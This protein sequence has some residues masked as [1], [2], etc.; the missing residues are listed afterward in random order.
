MTVQEYYYNM[1]VVHTE[2]NCPICNAPE[3][4]Q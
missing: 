1:G 3:V 2:G 4:T